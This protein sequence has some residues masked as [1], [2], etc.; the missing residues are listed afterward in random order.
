MGI[1]LWQGLGAGTPS[2]RPLTENGGKEKIQLCSSFDDFWLGPTPCLSDAAQEGQGG[3]RVKEIQT[4]SHQLVLKPHRNLPSQQQK[5]LPRVLFIL[6]YTELCK[7]M[8][9][10]LTRVCLVSVDALLRPPLLHGQIELQNISMSQVNN[11][12]WDSQR[13]AS[14]VSVSAV[15][16]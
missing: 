10:I 11:F 1:G 3:P 4:D 15:V 13:F 7:M 2:T 9:L 5:Q 16:G 8:L 12:V 14:T 6:Q